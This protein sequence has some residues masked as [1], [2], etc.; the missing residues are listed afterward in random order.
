[1]LTGVFFDVSNNMY[2]HSANEGRYNDQVTLRN[3][4][5]I[6]ISLHVKDDTTQCA[7]A[8]EIKYII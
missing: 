3:I 2:F 4:N 5:E 8:I 1:M 6:I 7:Q